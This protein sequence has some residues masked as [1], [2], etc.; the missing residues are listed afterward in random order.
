MT[1]FFLYSFVF[2]F[3]F[4]LI[5]LFFVFVKRRASMT[6]AI[7]ITNNAGQKFDAI[8]VKICENC[9]RT[10]CNFPDSIPLVTGS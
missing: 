5:V 10:Q 6:V 9:C 3:C 2:V 1:D 8:V 4:C 7:T